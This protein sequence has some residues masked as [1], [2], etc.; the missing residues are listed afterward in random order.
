MHLCWL[1][2]QDFRGGLC[3]QPGLE[4][5]V[6]PIIDSEGW[7]QNVELLVGEIDCF[8]RALETF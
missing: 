8:F 2:N 4:N 7:S 3:R 1:K 6:I 5:Q